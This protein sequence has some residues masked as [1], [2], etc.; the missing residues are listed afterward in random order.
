VCLVISVVQK[1]G[2]FCHNVGKERTTFENTLP[3][4]LFIFSNAGADLLYDGRN[5]DAGLSNIP[6]FTYD[7]K[8]HMGS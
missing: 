4:R 7:F 3:W 2:R 8:H 5:A 1:K 6:A